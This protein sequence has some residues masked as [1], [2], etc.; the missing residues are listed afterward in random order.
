VNIHDYHSLKNGMRRDS[1]GHTMMYKYNSLRRFSE[2]GEDRKDR[3]NVAKRKEVA[4]FGLSNFLN[5]GP[6]DRTLHSVWCRGIRLCE[7]RGTE[8]PLY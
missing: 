3:L 7:H 2:Y 6:K 8:L 5:L 1:S 4:W